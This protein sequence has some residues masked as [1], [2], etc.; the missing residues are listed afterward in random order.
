MIKKII[1]LGVNSVKGIGVNLK[2][3]K[4]LKIDLRYVKN[5]TKEI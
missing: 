3:G 4:I 5:L 1:F 2:V